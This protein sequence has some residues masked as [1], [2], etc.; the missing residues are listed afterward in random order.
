MLE[1]QLFSNKSYIHFIGIRV[2]VFCY[3][4]VKPRTLA[5]DC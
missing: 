2:L 5:K 1:S 3:F 4:K